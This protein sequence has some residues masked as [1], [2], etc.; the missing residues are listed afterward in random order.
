MSFGS[1]TPFHLHNLPHIRVSWIGEKNL[2][3]RTEQA[4]KNVYFE[5]LKRKNVYRFH[6]ISKPKE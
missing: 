5:L 4:V 1:L 6:P 3:F 2:R